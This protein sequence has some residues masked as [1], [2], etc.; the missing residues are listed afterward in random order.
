MFFRYELM[1]HFPLKLQNDQYLYQILLRMRDTIQ[2][3]VQ[4]NSMDNFTFPVLIE[5]TI[6]FKSVGNL[7]RK[8]KSNS[9]NYT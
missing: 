2:F 7:T 5:I 6:S 4:K 9:I 8:T 1:F 3:P